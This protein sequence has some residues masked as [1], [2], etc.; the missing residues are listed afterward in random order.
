MQG[1]SEKALAL[2]VL[3]VLS[4]HRSSA[5]EVDAAVLMQR[6]YFRQAVNAGTELGQ[7]KVKGRM[8]LVFSLSETF[9]NRNNVTMSVSSVYALSSL[10]PKGKKIFF[11]TPYL[12]F[13]VGGHMLF[14][15]ADL[16]DYS[17]F[18]K[19]GVAIK[20]HGICGAEFL[21]YGNSSFF[22]ETRYTYPSAIVL[23]YFSIGI[24]FN[25]KPSS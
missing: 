12:D 11:L 4:P 10:E 1:R 7:V 24:R 22:C 6:G 17:M 18:T 3:L 14:G 23:D 21:K 19:W 16:G 5:G 2:V 25:T 20:V 15:F 8:P 13:G 9:A